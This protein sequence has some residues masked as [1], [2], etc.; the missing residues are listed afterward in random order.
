MI[1][2]KKYDIIYIQENEK[3]KEIEM[4][5]S[6]IAKY[7]KTENIYS[8]EAIDAIK[9]YLKEQNIPFSFDC[10]TWQNDEGAT[11]G[12]AYVVEGRPQIFMF[13]VEG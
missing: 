6:I 11:C 9:A 7:E 3:E 4:L 8:I 1:F 10:A 2:I 13:E 12:F 5:S